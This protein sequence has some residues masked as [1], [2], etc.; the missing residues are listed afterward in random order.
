MD[1]QTTR[2]R[3]RPNLIL[4]PKQM[5]ASQIFSAPLVGEN[6]TALNKLHAP[7]ECVRQSPRPSAGCRDQRRPEV[8]R[9]MRRRKR[10]VKVA[11]R[12][13]DSFGL[14]GF[15]REVRED[16]IGRHNV[17]RTTRCRGQR[18]LTRRLGCETQPSQSGHHSRQNDLIVFHL[19]GTP[20]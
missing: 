9:T 16:E 20:H 2:L 4:L 18:A 17:S 19:P 7:Y 14:I 15:G 13:I 10:L 5:T 11:E 12:A 3:L 1:F 6:L 8:L